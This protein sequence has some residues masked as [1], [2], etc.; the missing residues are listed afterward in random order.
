M[1]SEYINKMEDKI[2][3]EVEDI[4]VNQ[5]EEE[6]P[7]KVTEDEVCKG[8]WMEMF[9][10]FKFINFCIIFM[11]LYITFHFEEAILFLFQFLNP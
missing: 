1:I 8:K 5:S 10:L 11:C 4:K 9:Y 3:E 7:L 6:D 2:K